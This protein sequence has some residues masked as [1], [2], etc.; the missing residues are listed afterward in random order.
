MTFLSVN[1]EDKTNQPLVDKYKVSGQTLLIVKGSKQENLTNVAFM[2]AKSNPD[3]L[4]KEIG[5][6]IG[7]L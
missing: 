3:K 2:H 5:K 1:I 6:A 7:N 4:K